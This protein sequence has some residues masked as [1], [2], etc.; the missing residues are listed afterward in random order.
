MKQDIATYS[1]L[2][3]TVIAYTLDNMPEELVRQFG[4]HMG[5][6]EEDMT[7]EGP[8][9]VE[10]KNPAWRVILK[11]FESGKTAEQIQDIVLGLTVRYY[12]RKANLLE[13]VFA[14]G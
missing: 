10:F 5:K 14:D 4:L 6:I 2:Q 3:D 13:G 11:A 1:Q 12:V 8:D 7:A 9:E